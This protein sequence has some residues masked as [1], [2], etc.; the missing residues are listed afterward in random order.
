MAVV[1]VHRRVRVRVLVR[2]CGEFFRESCLLVRE[3]VRVFVFVLTLPGTITALSICPFVV[4]LRG[5]S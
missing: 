5:S 4:E 1:C 3:R 2:V